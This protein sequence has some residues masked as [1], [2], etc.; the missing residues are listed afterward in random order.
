MRDPRSLECYHIMITCL[1]LSHYENCPLPPP[2]VHSASDLHSLTLEGPFVLCLSKESQIMGHQ[3][4]M[5]LS[6]GSKTCMNK[7]LDK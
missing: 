2:Q 6:D 5:L 3:G 7:L 1:T 4:Q